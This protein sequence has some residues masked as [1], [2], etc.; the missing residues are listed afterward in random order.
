MQISMQAAV[1]TLWQSR[2]NRLFYGLFENNEL[3]GI[4]LVKN[5]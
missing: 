5:I 2:N 3:Q 4:K 1:E